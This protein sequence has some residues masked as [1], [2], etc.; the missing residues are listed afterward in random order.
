M[1][2][3]LI[4]GSAGRIGKVL[5][6]A[7]ADEYDVFGLDR[8]PASRENTF[9]VDTTN[10]ADLK[11]TFQKISPHFVIHLAGNPD[12]SAS[13]E[14]IY[15]SNILGTRNVFGCAKEFGTKRVIF[16]S[17]THLIGAYS[18]YPQGPIENGRIL[19]VNDPT[20]PDSDYGSSKGYGELVARQFYDLYELESICIRI[21]AFRPHGLEGSN[22]IYRNIAISSRDLIQL[23]SKA[24]TSNVSFGIYFGIS[25]NSHSFLDISNAEKDL[26]YLPQNSFS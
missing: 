23:F 2:K 8:K 3:L 10:L 19:T 22:D 26:G 9:R 11:T 17:S 7:F 18:G 25:N 16:A 5:V 20:K 21:G 13:W 15:G 14:E 4:T 12:E 1:E 6:K 24:L